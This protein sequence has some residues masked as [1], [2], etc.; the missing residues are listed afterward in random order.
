MID[1]VIPAHIKDIDTLVILKKML[2]M[3]VEFLLYQEIDSQ[4]MLNG[5]QKKISHL[6]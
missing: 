6:L 4:K 5:F 2:L 3:L 1:V